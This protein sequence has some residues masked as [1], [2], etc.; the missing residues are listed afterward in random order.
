VDYFKLGESASSWIASKS[1]AAH[2]A[3]LRQGRK[4]PK[5]WSLFWSKNKQQWFYH[6]NATN[7]KVWKPPPVDGWEIHPRD[8]EA[9]QATGAAYAGLQYYEYN[10]LTKAS[11]FEPPQNA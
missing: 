1:A 5:V 10:P 8:A 6:N 11:A 2:A 3:A 4:D 7:D 9:V